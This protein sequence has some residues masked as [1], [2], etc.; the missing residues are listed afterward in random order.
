MMTASWGGLG[1][2]WN[3]RI[4]ITFVRPTRYTREFIEKQDLFTCSFFPAKYRKALSFCGSHSGR[5]VNKTAATGLTPVFD[6]KGAVYFA[7][8]RLV[9][10]CRK[11]YFQDLEPKQFL[12]RKVL[13]M[14]PEKDFHRM[15]F[16][17]IAKCLKR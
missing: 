7:E 5:D 13:K 17:E 10:V 4:A 15:Y 8:A 14:Y 9:L 3:K 2:I 16:G 11:I 1:V 6:V 12:D